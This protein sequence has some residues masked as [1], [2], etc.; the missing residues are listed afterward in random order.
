MEQGISLFTQ[1]Y[2]EILMFVSKNGPCNKNDVYLALDGSKT[3]RIK[4]VNELLEMGLISETKLGLYNRKVIEITD[5]GL[6]ILR[7]MLEIRAELND[8]L[9]PRDS[10]HPGASPQDDAMPEALD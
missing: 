4:H 7:K 5:K 1:H 10:D 6:S 2:Y 8:E 3:T 9:V